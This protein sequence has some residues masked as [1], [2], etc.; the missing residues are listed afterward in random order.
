MLFAEDDLYVE[1]TIFKGRAVLL[2][3]FDANAVDWT[4]RLRFLGDLK[5]KRCLRAFV[6]LHRKILLKKSCVKNI[7]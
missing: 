1:V 7:N 3:N 2:G 5:R 4:N 6:C